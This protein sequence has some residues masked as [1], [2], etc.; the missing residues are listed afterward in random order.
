MGLLM[1]PLILFLVLL[2]FG[3]VFGLRSIMSKNV[4]LA[5]KHLDDL[6]Q[7]YAQKEKEIQRQRD[8]LKL[9]SQE[10]LSKSLDEAE[11]QKMQIVKSSQEEK[12]KLLD[13]AKQKAE[14]LMQQA[15]QAR[16]SLLQEIEHKI[17]QRATEKAL[18][19]LQ[20]VLPEGLRQDI[21]SRWVSDLIS[22]GLEELE[23]L[24]VKEGI[25]EARIVTAFA[26]SPEQKNALI[27]KLR[28]KLKYQLEL[29]EEIDPSII[30]GLIVYIGSIIF[31]GSLKSKIKEAVYAK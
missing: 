3:L 24:K 28:E 17:D 19:L 30:S 29:K 22:A 13:A 21:H 10:I 26:L 11:K 12:G 18:E 25:E 5:T 8:D 31:D 7:E 1:V 15:E 2:F 6:N 4:V 27:H 20:K 23:R 16:Q 9:K 14:E